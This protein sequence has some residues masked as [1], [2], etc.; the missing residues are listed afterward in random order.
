MVNTH[1]KVLMK[2]H[3]DKWCE[4]NRLI[5]SM[6][7]QVFFSEYSKEVE[8]ILYCHSTWYCIWPIT[9]TMAGGGFK[10][11][12]KTTKLLGPTVQASSKNIYFL[13]NT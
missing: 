9:K 11:A 13:K 5:P 4:V 10:P 3:V 7:F 2:A 12:P 1:N 8:K 6:L